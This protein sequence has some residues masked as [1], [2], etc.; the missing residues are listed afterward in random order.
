MTHA[1]TDVPQQWPTQPADVVGATVC[2]LSGLRAPDPAPGD[3]APRYEYF[4]RGTIPD[5]QGELRR[6]IPIFKPSQAPATS[7]QITDQPEEIEYQNHAV[8][9]DPL[10]TMLCLDCAGGYGEATVVRLDQHGKAI[11]N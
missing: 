8:I 5:F 3:C 7:R 2:S 6:D 11:R 10:G 4:I 1:L 9:F